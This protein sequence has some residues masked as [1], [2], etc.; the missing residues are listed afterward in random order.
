[1][2]FKPQLVLI[3]T[4]KCLGVLHFRRPR[5]FLLQPSRTSLCRALIFTVLT[6]CLSSAA[7]ADRI[8]MLDGKGRTV[9]GKI[10]GIS[11]EKITVDVRGERQ[12]IAANIIATTEFDGE[13]GALKT[14]RTAVT[15]SR[16][17]EALEALDKVD[18]KTLTND[19]LKQEAAYIRAWSKAKLVL[20]GSGN[21]DDA[22]KELS[23]FIKDH[24]NS[25]HFYEICELYGD[26]MVQQ[27]KFDRAKSSYAALAKAPWPE[28]SHKATVSL[29]MAEVSENKIDSARKNFESVINAKSEGDDESDQTERI[30]GMAKVGL[31]LCLTAEKKYDEAIKELEKIAENSGSEDSIFQSLVYNSL[32]ATFEK[33]GKPREAILAFMHTDI[34][35]SSART[36]HIKALTELSKLWKQVKRVER[37]EAIEN[38]LKDLYNISI[39]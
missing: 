7:L 31:A 26:L 28:Y 22:E 9:T 39:K 5:L 15:G 14:A 13:P 36:E 30:K 8:T 21:A 4:P 34:L 16:M 29:G 24:K 32:G 2:P 10:L 23:A 6:V 18:P 27:G 17:T 11:A 3:R 19:F 12:D 1:M 20:A 33:A 25:Y 38:R 37:A 35:F